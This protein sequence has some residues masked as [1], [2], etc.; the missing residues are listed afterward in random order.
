MERDLIAI[1]DIPNRPESVLSLN[2]QQSEAATKTS[3]EEVK[4]MLRQFFEENRAEHQNLLID[5]LRLLEKENSTFQ[6]ELDALK[7]FHESREQ[8]IK[9]ERVHNR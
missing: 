5:K 3:N 1:T 7:Q 6:E 4:S 2:Q 8:D 9:N